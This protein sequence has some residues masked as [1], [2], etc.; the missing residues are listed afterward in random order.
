MS[1]SYSK[2]EPIAIIV[3]KDKKIDKKIIKLSTDDD[4]SKEINIENGKLQVLPSL[5][6]VERLYISGPSG[7]GKSYF[8][9]KWLSMNRKM[10]KNK[11]KKDIIILSRIKK[12]EQLDKFKP[13]RPGLEEMLEDPYT[14]EDLTNEIVIFDDVD[15]IRDKVVKNAVYNL[16]N[17]LLV[18]GRHFW[19]TVICTSHI[20]M[21]RNESKFCLNEATTIVIFPK[22]GQTYQ[23]KRL[24]KEYMG[25]EKKL[26]NKIMKL[27]SR[28]V[29]MR[30]IYPITIIHEKGAFVANIDLD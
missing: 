24:L 14:G 26:I 7:S 25:F 11:N 19:V 2:G 6:V 18:C 3:S 22:S 28:W 30:R 23:I 21:D 15:S 27:P 5:D 4:G 17:D 12:D 16:R 8:I 20:I 29:A 1:L 13:E 9:S 10:Y